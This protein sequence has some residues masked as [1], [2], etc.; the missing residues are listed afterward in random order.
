M[1]LSLSWIMQTVIMIGVGCIAYFAKENHKSVK[2][3]MTEIKT[4]LK[5]TDKKIK[6]AREYTDIKVNELN[7]E[8]NNLKADL[9]FIY[10]TRGDHVRQ[11]NNIDAKMGG[12]D[13]KLDSIF[14]LLSC[15]KEG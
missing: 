3:S 15:K 12:M 8:F 10:V 7:K 13:K 9:P 1:E 14:V 4:S 6:E 2:D 11:M 5:D